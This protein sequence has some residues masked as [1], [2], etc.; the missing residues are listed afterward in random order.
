MKSAE[1]NLGTYDGDE[2]NIRLSMDMDTFLSDDKTTKEL[3]L[4]KEHVGRL[5]EISGGDLQKY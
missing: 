2:A 4:L 3:K 1:D 5:L